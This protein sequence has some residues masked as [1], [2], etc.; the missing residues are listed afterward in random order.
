MPIDPHPTPKRL[1]R[2]NSFELDITK[3]NTVDDIKR[4]VQ[5]VW[6]LHLKQQELLLN[7]IVNE[8]KNFEEIDIHQTNTIVIGVKAATITLYVK[9]LNSTL[10]FRF[11][12]VSLQ[13]TVKQFK[14]EAADR[15]I[16]LQQ[17]ATWLCL[18]DR[19]LLDHEYLRAIPKLDDESVLLCRTTVK[20]A[21]IS[22]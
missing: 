19:E 12:D 6:G 1:R 9:P 11:V 3:D 5:E 10:N 16:D 8:N 13:W 22:L 21:S 2:F 17:R 7:G 14:E 18:E 4:K 20:G 15:V